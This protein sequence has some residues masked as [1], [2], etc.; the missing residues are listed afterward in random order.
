MD[1]SIKKEGSDYNAYAGS[2]KVVSGAKTA[3]QAVSGAVA[4]QM[5]QLGRADYTRITGDLT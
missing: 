1:V 3:A 5:V 4:W 2:A